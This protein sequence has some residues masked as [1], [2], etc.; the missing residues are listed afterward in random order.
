MKPSASYCGIEISKDGY[1]ISPKRKQ[2]L[3]DYPDFDIRKRTKNN[4]LKYLG[5]YNWHRRFVENY[6]MHD[7]EFRNVIKRYKNKEIDADKANESIKEI[8]DTIKSKILK[9]MLIIVAIAD[10]SRRHHQQQQL[11]NITTHIATIS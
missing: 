8:T 10:I 6:S 4:D 5:F 2:I 7:R 1:A 3:K 9:T 11:K